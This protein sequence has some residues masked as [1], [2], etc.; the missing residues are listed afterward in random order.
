MKL[1]MPG[2]QRNIDDDE[3]NDLLN[4]NIGSKGSS[5]LVEPNW[6]IG[7]TLRETTYIPTCETKQPTGFEDD[8]DDYVDYSKQAKKRN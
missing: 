5:G 7:G 4:D 8:Y 2:E 3:I 6:N 1:L